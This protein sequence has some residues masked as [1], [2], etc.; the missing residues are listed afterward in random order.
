MNTPSVL[1][2]EDE[3]LLRRQLL[4]TL[5]ELWPELETIT[6]A[7]SGAEALAEIA[8]EV[9]DIA[10]LDIN[11]PDMSGIEIARVLRE[12]AQVVFVTAYSEYAVAAFEQHALDYVL[13]PATPKRLNDTVRRL[14]ER[15]VAVSAAPT[16][17][18]TALAE[19]AQRLAPK[20]PAMQWIPVGVGNTL[21]L[22]PLSDVVAFNADDKYTEVLTAKGEAL[23]R[24]P[25]KELVEELPPEEFWQIHR[26][27]I[28]R[29]AAI[30]KV[31]RDESGH[32]DVH[33]RGFPRRFPVSRS[34]TYR[35]RQI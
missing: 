28:V 3:P 14:R 11:L 31:T 19:L 4:E 8:R 34:Y 26:S 7:A 23:I 33:L 2:V 25:I 17:T 13:K 9:P 15:L 5:S 30:E 18:S 32:L 29:V 6:E 22:V 24:K 10:F 21:Q 16:L 27:T 1:I 35:F 20:A 12:R